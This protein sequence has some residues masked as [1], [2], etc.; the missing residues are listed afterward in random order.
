ML[1]SCCLPLH[2]LIAVS[3][4]NFKMEIAKKSWPVD[5][6]YDFAA[7]T[8]L[9]QMQPGTW[10]DLKGWIASVEMKDTSGTLAKQV[11]KLRIGDMTTDLELLGAHAP[12]HA[13]SSWNR[14]DLKRF[15]CCVRRAE[16]AHAQ[17]RKATR[18][19]RASRSTLLRF[20]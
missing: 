8:D 7:Y 11:I 4:Y 3:W 19:K 12:S 9:N 1:A 17:P 13:P 15:S 5:I 14:A 16:K 6:Q 2:H 18:G 20:H 10:L